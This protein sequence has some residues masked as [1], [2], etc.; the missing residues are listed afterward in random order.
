M[1]TSVFTQTW[2]ITQA[3]RGGK[4]RS[5]Y[6]FS[7]VKSPFQLLSQSLVWRFSFETQYT[8]DYLWFFPM[9][10]IIKTIPDA[11]NQN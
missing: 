9:E 4:E 1:E 5:T 11:Q 7:S 10:H 6:G 3:Y 2:K 8:Q